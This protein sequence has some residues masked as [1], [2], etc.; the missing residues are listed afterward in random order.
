MYVCVRMICVCMCVHDLCMYN[1]CVHDLCVC[2]C[3]LH[4]CT[5][6][7]TL[8]DVGASGVRRNSLLV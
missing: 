7:L 1:V 6:K 4:V 3:V 8:D 5:F 2:V